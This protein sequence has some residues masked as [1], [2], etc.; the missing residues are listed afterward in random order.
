MFLYLFFYIIFLKKFTCVSH[1]G[2]TI[3]TGYPQPETAQQRK[4]CRKINIVRR[5]I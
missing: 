2:L 5:Y 3:S 4:Q 1:E